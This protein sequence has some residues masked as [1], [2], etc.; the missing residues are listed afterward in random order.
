M[1]SSGIPT[2]NTGRASSA[3]HGPA[4]DPV[5]LR[6]SR[7]TREDITA[8]APGLGRASNLRLWRENLPALVHA[9]LEVDV[10]RAAQ[11]AGILV[12]DIAR[13]AQRVG[14]TA[15]AAPGRR[16]FSL[17]DSHGVVLLDPL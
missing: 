11:L 16:G 2:R 3:V 1:I 13:L 9:G 4:A 6:R 12:L 15:H 5:R 8:G 17:R 7:R 14:G 10:M